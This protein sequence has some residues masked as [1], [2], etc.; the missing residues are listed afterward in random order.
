MSKSFKILCALM[1]LAFGLAGAGCGPGESL[2]LSAET[3]DAA[4]REGQQLVKQGRPQ[5]A[6]STFLRVIAR[7]G[8]ASDAT[9]AVLERA[10]QADP[11]P[12]DW[13]RLDAAGDALAAARN[14]LGVAG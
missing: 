3:D 5:E 6:L 11:G 9:I 7:R 2:G 4:Y 13:R 10:A 8:E 14:A 12:I 1:V